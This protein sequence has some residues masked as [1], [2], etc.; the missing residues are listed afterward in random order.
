MRPARPV[1]AFGDTAVIVDVGSVEE[2]HGL[3]AAIAAGDRHGIE[4]VIVGFG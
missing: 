3:A 1:R 2:A 4:A